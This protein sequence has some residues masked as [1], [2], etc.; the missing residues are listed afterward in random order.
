MFR[1]LYY[2]C[3]YAYLIYRQDMT[4]FRGHNGPFARRA[5]A[6]RCGPRRCLLAPP[7]C[8]VE[9]G[10]RWAGLGWSNSTS[11]DRGRAR[12]TGTRRTPHAEPKIRHLSDIKAVLFGR[13]KANLRRPRAPGWA[14]HAPPLAVAARASLLVLGAERPITSQGHYLCRS[15]LA[16]REMKIKW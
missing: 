3:A 1:L 10:R 4:P 11:I 15:A 12:R 13:T 7:R 9:L 8:R 16:T 14:R 6:G 2:N 5:P